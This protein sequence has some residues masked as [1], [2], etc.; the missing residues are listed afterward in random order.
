MGNGS[1]LS[2][3]GGS[4]YEKRARYSEIFCSNDFPGFFPISQDFSGSAKLIFD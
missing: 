1:F 4:G 2:N 3:F